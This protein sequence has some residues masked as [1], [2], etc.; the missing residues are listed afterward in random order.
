M[1]RVHCT[2]QGYLY[3]MYG[4]YDTSTVFVLPSTV[5]KSTNSANVLQRTIQCHDSSGS[6]PQCV[7]SRAPLNQH[8]VLTAVP[9]NSVSAGVQENAAPFT[10]T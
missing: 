4:I 7:L 10:E 2:V 6:S 5:S 3:S 8:C 9:M 1:R